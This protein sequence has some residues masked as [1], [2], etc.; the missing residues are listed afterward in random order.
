MRIAYLS[1]DGVNVSLAVEI[2]ERHG[3]ALS[4]VEPRDGTPGPEFDG[5][6]CDWDCWPVRGRQDRLAALLVEARSRPV[7]LHGYSVEDV[8]EEPLRRHGVIVYTVLHAEVFQRLRQ[9]ILAARVAA[10]AGEGLVAG[11]RRADG[12]A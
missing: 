12:A 7:A 11:D 9:A 5:V 8:E 10:A 4:V 1:I 3:I 6:L 2:A